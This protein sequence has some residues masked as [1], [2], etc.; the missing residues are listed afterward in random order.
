MNLLLPNLTTVRVA[1]LCAILGMTSLCASAQTQAQAIP[2]TQKVELPKPTTM[3][4][5]FGIDGDYR[6]GNIDRRLFK[7]RLSLNYETPKS[8]LGFNTNPRYSYGTFKGALNENELFLDWNTTFYA[9]Q[10]KLY[11]LC[12]GMAEKSNLRKI[13]SRFLGGAG[14][15]Y[16]ILG[17]KNSKTRYKLAITDAIIYEA[18]NYL[19][20]APIDVI[21]NSTRIK[22]S[23]EIIKDVLFLNNNTFIQPAL[24]K[25][26]FRWNAITQLSVRMSKTFFVNAILDNSYESVVPDGAK[27]TDI[28]FSFG[29]SYA[30][31]IFLTSRTRLKYER[32]PHWWMNR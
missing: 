31:D 5:N 27:N 4:I 7:T 20:K 11:Y 2:K 29:L 19:T 32:D 17:D 3:Q 8:I 14:I 10:R 12:F 1:A 23:G 24:N 16:R 18:T 6:Q 26:N 30:G 25:P 15:G 9:Y 28:A 22:F 21:R 13:N